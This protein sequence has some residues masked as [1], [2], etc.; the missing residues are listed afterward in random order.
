MHF[1]LKIRLWLHLLQRNTTHTC[2]PT[3]IAIFFIQ[4]DTTA[5]LKRLFKFFS[6]PFFREISNGFDGKGKKKKKKAIEAHS[7]GP[8]VCQVSPPSLSIEL[9]VRDTIHSHAKKNL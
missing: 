6:F 2:V 1:L 9:V 7:V 5:H 4:W 3:S 8:H